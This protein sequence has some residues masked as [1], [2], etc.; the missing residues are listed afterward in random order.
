MCAREIKII[1]DSASFALQSY[2]SVQTLLLRWSSDCSL[3]KAKVDAL[4]FKYVLFIDTPRLTQYFTVFFGRW[5]ASRSL[6]KSKLSTH[7]VVL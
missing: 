7:F 4:F 6:R 3:Y 5:E 1:F 2:E